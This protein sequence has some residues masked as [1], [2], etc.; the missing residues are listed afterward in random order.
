MYQALVVR[1]S[2]DGASVHHCDYPVADEALLDADLSADMDALLRLVSLGSAARNTVKVKVRQPLAEMKV[3]PADERERR[4]I[5]RFSD[6]ICEELNVKRVSLHPPD[7]GPLLSIEVKLNMKTAGPKFGPRLKAVHAALDDADAA[8]LSSVFQ[9]GQPFTLDLPDGPAVLEPG[10]VVIQMRASQGW[11]GVADRGTQV[12]LDVRITEALAREGM[13]RD[14]VRQVQELRK[15]AKLELEDRIALHLRTD[16]ETLE[17][18]IEAHK[19]YIASETLATQ[20][21]HE[22]LNGDSHSASVKVDGK[23]LRVQLR[24]VTTDEP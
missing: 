22:P 8:A 4:A 11:A 1:G 2:Q 10:D 24:K 5:E 9:S 3:Q 18:A 21:I 14:V 23:P 20:W 16:S 15:S 12:A 6:Q 7:H 17:Q 19:A 13:A